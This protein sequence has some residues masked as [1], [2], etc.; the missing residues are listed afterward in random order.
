MC[1][2]AEE[3]RRW[4][5]RQGRRPWVEMEEAMSMAVF[6]SSSSESASLLSVIVL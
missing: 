3:E 4:S 5:V 1:R 2:T 6:L